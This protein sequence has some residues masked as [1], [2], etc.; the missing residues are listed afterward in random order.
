MRSLTSV[1]AFAFAVLPAVAGAQSADSQYCAALADKYDAYLD[2]A[3]SMGG[4]ATPVE[5]VVAMDK[6]KSDPK[7][8]IPV[9]E[10]QLKAAKL[11]LPPHP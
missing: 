8:A 4:R 9:L 10:K 11:A 7:S 5:V 3:G 2:T 1:I 6:C